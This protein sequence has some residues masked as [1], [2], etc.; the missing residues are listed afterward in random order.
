MIRSA[1]HFVTPFI[2][3]SLAFMPAAC[4][5]SSDTG[6]SLAAKM[7]VPETTVTSG[8]YKNDV[9][10]TSMSVS[11]I[12]LGFAPYA[13]Q[14]AGVDATLDLNLE[15]P[16]ESSVAFDL[17]A[18]SV[19]SSYRGDFKATHQRSPHDTW[20]EA[21]AVNYLG[22]DVQEIITF[23]STRFDYA[24][25]TTGTLYGDLSMNGLTK[26][27]QFDIEITGEG[28]HP[29]N[30]REG[31]GVV[32]TGTISRADYDIAQNRNKFLSD[33]V[34]VTFSADFLKPAAE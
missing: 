31:V 12:H 5:Q 30:Q 16:S 32:A 2:L 29:F 14:L 15:N 33:E 22:A 17:D 21:V 24:G 28:L 3:M 25:G 4:A 26:L 20:E 34:T 13:V 8:V 23:R 27:A 18:N 10:H 1:R 9:N 7:T 19:F 6:E 11:L